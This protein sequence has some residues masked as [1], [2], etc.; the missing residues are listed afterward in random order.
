MAVLRLITCGGSIDRES[1]H[2]LD[3]VIV[4]ASLERLHSRSQATVGTPGVSSRGLTTAAA[5]VSS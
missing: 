3:N 2:Y 5:A 1:G 4:F